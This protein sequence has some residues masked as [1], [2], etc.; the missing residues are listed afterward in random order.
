[1]K[2][3]IYIILSVFSI[4]PAALAQSKVVVQEVIRE[5]EE[6]DQRFPVKP[7]EL[8]EAVK[9]ALS[10]EQYK[11]W[12]VTEAF[13]IQE[14]RKIYEITLMKGQEKQVIKMDEQ[15]NVLT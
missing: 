12:K 9:K 5:K 4:G 8:P 10:D 11:D 1:M 2:T 7:E 3:I 13:L 15:G 14:E 6:G